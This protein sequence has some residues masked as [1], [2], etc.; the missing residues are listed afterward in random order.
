[1][2]NVAN[3]FLTLARLVLQ[4]HVGAFR[5]IDATEFPLGAELVAEA[6]SLAIRITED[7]GDIMF[8]VAGNADGE[9]MPIQ[10]LAILI[11]GERASREKVSVG[12]DRGVLETF[13][14]SFAVHA[15]VLRTLLA[16]ENVAQT[17]A[18]VLELNRVFV[19]PLLR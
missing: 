10:H 7:R 1:M 9:W 16:P 6:M 3:D 4:K 12:K 18:R 13:C 8:E 11:T 19:H 17:K 2:E 15:S 5:E 14:A